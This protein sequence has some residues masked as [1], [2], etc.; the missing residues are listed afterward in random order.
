MM[1]ILMMILLDEGGHGGDYVYKEDG[2]HDLDSTAPSR[3]L[4]NRELFDFSPAFY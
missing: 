1:M 2:D 4:A 3:I